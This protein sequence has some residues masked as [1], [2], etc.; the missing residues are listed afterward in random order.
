MRSL[1]P[2]PAA[3]ALVLAA[4]VAAAAPAACAAGPDEPAADA[5]EELT[6]EV[7]ATRP[8]DPEAFTQGLAWSD[9]ALYESTGRYGRS[10]VRRVDSESG[11][12]LAGADLPAELFGEGLAVVPG[13]RGVR[14]VQLTWLEEVAWVW[15]AATL[16]PAGIHHYDGEGW[17]L[18]FDGGRLVMSDGSDVLTLRDAASFEIAGRVAVTLRGR[19]LEGLNELECAEGWVWANVLGA[20]S[21]VR[22][23]PASGRVTAVVDASDLLTPAE[24]AAADV[25]NGIAYDPGR[26]VYHLTGK[27]WPKRFEVRFVSRPSSR[28]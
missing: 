19:P 21:V 8:H 13:E 9:G 24:A 11:R 4:V 12:T 15:D 1:R 17:G 27:L 22:I 5:V 14:L 7:L 16:E 10:S 18:C 6:V 26:R 2:R 25:L 20:D 3:A 23:D 28:P